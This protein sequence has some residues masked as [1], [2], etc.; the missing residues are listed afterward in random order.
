MWCARQYREALRLVTIQRHLVIADEVH[1][2]RRVG[3]EVVERRG[4][5]RATFEGSTGRG[6]ED[7]VLGEHTRESLA[8]AGV[9]TDRISLHELAEFETID[10]VLDSTHDKAPIIRRHALVGRARVVEREDQLGKCPLDSRRSKPLGSSV[11]SD[12]RRPTRPL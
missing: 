8:I 7:S 9:R 2:M 3:V 6:S 1:R 12:F 5:R 10:C 4:D 11:A